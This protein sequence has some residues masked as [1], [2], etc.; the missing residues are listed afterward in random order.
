MHDR[1]AARR[2]DFP[3]YNGAPAPLTSAG[4]LI[5][6]AACAAAFFALL[7]IPLRMP[8]VGG[9][10]LAATAFVALQ[11]AGLALAVGPAWVALFRRPRARDLLVGL[12]SVPLVIGVPLL[13]GYFVVGEAN[14][15]VNA[16]IESAGDLSALQ[17]LNRF[18]TA[19]L[20]LVGEELITILPLLVVLALLH[21]SGMRRAPAIAIAWVITSLAFGALHLSTYQWHFGQA[22]LVIGA[23]RF[24][25]TGVYL[26]T[27]NIWASTIAHIAND[28]SM[29]ALA[30]LAAAPH[31]S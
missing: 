13:V 18:A 3:F 9:G 25:L 26:L 17:A 1:Q 10:W 7:W 12:A 30:L 14:L 11:L 24:V 6:L 2:S 19:A 4:S 27:R 23:A 16:V 28:W 15:S 31:A 21:R 20:Q 5:V 29:M 22:L 8:G